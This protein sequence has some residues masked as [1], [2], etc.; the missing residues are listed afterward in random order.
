MTAEAKDKVFALVPKAM[1]NPFF[2]QARDGCM[3]AAK[4]IGG[5]PM[6]VHRPG[7]RDRAGAGAGR[8]GP[9]HQACRRHWRLGRQRPGDR[10]GARPRQGGQD[11]G[12]D[13][14]QRPAAGRQGP[15]RELYRHGQRAGRHRGRQAGD[16]AQ[17]ERRHLL[18]PDRRTGRGQHE[19][20]HQ[21]HDGD[22]ARRQVEAGR[23]LPA[24]QQRRLPAVDH[25][26]HRSSG[27]VSRR[28][29]PS[30][31]RAARRRWR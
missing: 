31:T 27:Q 10:Q 9:H 20:P 26:A 24:L 4:E 22:P 13:L 12:R 1:N 15:A 7:R 17:A 8:P 21:G 3:K 16:G 11:P 18:H 23:G 19:R 29:T 28:S 2:D 30:S 14:G 25:P 5:D 6:P